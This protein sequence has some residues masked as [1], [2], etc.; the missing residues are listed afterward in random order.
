M[1]M[2]MTSNRGVEEEAELPADTGA[3]QALPFWNIREV[4]I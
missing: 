4:F 3:W 1:S 2:R